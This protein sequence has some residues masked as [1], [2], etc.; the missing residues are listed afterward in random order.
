MQK[1]SI[2]KLILKKLNI[3]KNMSTF[4]AIF[5]EGYIYYRGVEQW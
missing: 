2:N 5:P 1:Y 3:K 4:A